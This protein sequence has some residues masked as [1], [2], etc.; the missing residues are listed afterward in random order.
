MKFT[1][2]RGAGGRGD[3]PSFFNFTVATGQDFLYRRSQALPLPTH[4]SIKRKEPR[5]DLIGSGLL[6]CPLC[7]T[8]R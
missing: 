3:S 6:L 2:G 7:L 5:F 1:R 8:P 4:L